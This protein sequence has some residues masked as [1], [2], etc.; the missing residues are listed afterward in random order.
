MSFRGR[1]RLFFALIVI[2]PMIALGVVLFALTA[3]SETGKADA[4]LAAGSRSATGIYR[5]D[6]ERARPSLHRIAG[7]RELQHALRSGRADEAERRLRELTIGGVVA[8]ELSLRGERPVRTGSTR[9]VAFSG[10]RLVVRDARD[11]VL[12]VSVTNASALA[13]RVMTLSGFEVVVSRGGR[14]LASTLP[15]AVRAVALPAEDLASLD[16]GGE[17]YRGRFVSMEAPAGP[18]VRLGVL[19]PTASF[20]EH[21]ANN[22]LLIALL[23]GLFVL[24]A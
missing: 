14:S 19:T 16:V 20:S 18:P 5:E 17:D 2:V 1:L 4:G 10:S 13:D 7:D 21:I 9:A 15:S 24:L 6:A 11:A 8:A 3:R 12:S 23:V 22:R